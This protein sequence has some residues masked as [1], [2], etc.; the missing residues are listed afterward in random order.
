MIFCDAKIVTVRPVQTIR[1]YSDGDNATE[2]IVLLSSAVTL[3]SCMNANGM[4]WIKHCTG[5]AY[6]ISG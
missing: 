5:S 4:L 2:P 6:F 1:M 3:C